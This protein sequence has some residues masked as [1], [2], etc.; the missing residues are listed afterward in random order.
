[1]PNLLVGDPVVYNGQRAVIAAVNPTKGTVD[2][3][4]NN[5]G[6]VQQGVSV[7]SVRKVAA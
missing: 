1:M 5:G 7:G 6:A 2:V 3:R 4:F